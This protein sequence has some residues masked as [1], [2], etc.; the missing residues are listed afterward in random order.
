[1]K[2]WNE[3]LKTVNEGWTGTEGDKAYDEILDVIQD[4]KPEQILTLIWNYFDE[5]QLKK[6][7]KWMEQDEYF[8]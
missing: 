4:W 7:Y 5:D 8:K 1:M 3:Y 6:L 2:N